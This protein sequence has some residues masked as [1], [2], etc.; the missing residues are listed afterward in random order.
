MFRTEKLYTAQGGYVSD[1]VIPAFV[2]KP[3]VLIWGCRVFMYADAAMLDEAEG[4]CYI[5]VFGYFVP[6]SPDDPKAP[7][8]LLTRDDAPPD[9]PKIVLHSSKDV[10]RWCLEVIKEGDF[11][12]TKDGRT[13]CSHEHAEVYEK[14]SGSRIY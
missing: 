5:E 7:A 10:C 4:D 11:I 14:N 6:P 12:C 2:E 9:A 3:P 1:V 13:F 8:T